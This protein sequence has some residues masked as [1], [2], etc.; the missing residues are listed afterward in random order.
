MA[1][2]K[3]NKDSKEEEEKRNSF[4]ENLNSIDFNNEKVLIK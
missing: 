3:K 4:L 2:K 1:I